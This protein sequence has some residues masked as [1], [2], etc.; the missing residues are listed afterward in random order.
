MASCVQISSPHQLFTGEFHIPV[1]NPSMCTHLFA[2]QNQNLT[3][4]NEE[5]LYARLLVNSYMIVPWLVEGN[6]L[7]ARSTV[8]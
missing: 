2:S 8:L 5:D 7:K 1:L 6:V 3:R 4:G